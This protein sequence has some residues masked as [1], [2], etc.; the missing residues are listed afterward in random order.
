MFAYVIVFFVSLTIGFLTG[1]K[2]RS[3]KFST[4][5]WVLMKWNEGSLGYRI[6]PSSTATIRKGEKAYLCIEVNT[7]HLARGEEFN[8]FEG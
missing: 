7:D 2:I 6:T 4:L 8:I 5:P 3:L 1:D